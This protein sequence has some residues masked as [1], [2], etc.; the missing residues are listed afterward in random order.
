MRCIL[1]KAAPDLELQIEKLVIPPPPVATPISRMGLERRQA[2]IDAHHS[3]GMPS[4]DR[5]LSMQSMTGSYSASTSVSSVLAASMD[6]IIQGYPDPS[7]P[8]DGNQMQHQLTGLTREDKASKNPMLASLLDQDTNSPETQPPSMLSQLLNNGDNVSGQGK[9]KK[10]R[11]RKSMSDVRSPGSSGRSPK[12]KPNED[13]FGA[14]REFPGMDMDINSHGMN[15]YDMSGV[16]GQEHQHVNLQRPQQQQQAAYGNSGMHVESHVSRLA[17]SVDNIIKQESKNFPSV[18]HQPGMELPQPPPYVHPPMLFANEIKQEQLGNM[19]APGIKREGIYTQSS[20]TN[21]ISKGNSLADLLKTDSPTSESEAMLA[22][23]PP[24]VTASSSLPKK[25]L[26][27]LGQP[28]SDKSVGLGTK[29]HKSF[30][31]AIS[32]SSTKSHDY[33]RSNSV[34]ILDSSP[35]KIK[36]E[37]GKSFNMLATKNSIGREKTK[38]ASDSRLEIKPEDKQGNVVKDKVKEKKREEDQAP[39]LTLKLKNVSSSKDLTPGSETPPL[40]DPFDHAKAITPKDPPKL[41]FKEKF[42]GKDH[43]YDLGSDPEEA[44]PLPPLSHSRTTTLSSESGKPSSPAV[45]IRKIKSEDAIKLSKKIKSTNKY[46][47]DH[48]RKKRKDR[49]SDGKKDKIKRKK[50]YDID[51]E[52]STSSGDQP[53]KSAGSSPNVFSGKPMES[54]MSTTIRISNVAGKLQITPKPNSSSLTQAK[55]S[56]KTGGTTPSPQGSKPLK[57]TSSASKINRPP[58]SSKQFNRSRSDPHGTGTNR[59]DTKLTSKTPTIKLKPLVIPSSTAT[60]TVNASSS[61]VSHSSSG[62]STSSQSGSKSASTE[63][64]FSKSSSKPLFQ[65]QRKGSLSAV[66]ENLTNKQRGPPT[67][68]QKL[69]KIE[70]RSGKGDAVSTKNK[71]D[72]IYKAILEAAQGERK[73]KSSQR[74][75][76]SARLPSEPGFT[77]LEKSG[78]LDFSSSGT[79]PA[80]LPSTPIP[81]ISKTTGASPSGLP[82]IPKIG[83]ASKSS[84]GSSI[85]NKF[86]SSTSVLARSA[87]NMSSA[88]SSETTKSSA[89]SKEASYSSK[90]PSA[91]LGGSQAGKSKSGTSAVGGSGSSNQAS[92]DALRKES[93]NTFRKQD[94][95]VRYNDKPPRDNHSPSLTAY[96]SQNP[97]NS[98]KDLT[99]SEDGAK[100]SKLDDSGDR[101]QGRHFMDALG[102]ASS[103][104]NKGENSGK[105]EANSR[106]SYKPGMKRPSQAVSGGESSKSEQYHSSGNSTDRS[107]LNGLNV[108]SGSSS[109][110]TSPKEGTTRSEKTSVKEFST[111]PTSDNPVNSSGVDKNSGKSVSMNNKQVNNV[112]FNHRSGKQHY[113]QPPIGG[114][115]SSAPKPTTNQT[116]HVSAISSNSKL[117]NSHSESLTTSSNDPSTQSI[118]AQSKQDSVG[119]FDNK[120]NTD[121]ASPDPEN[122]VFKAPTP[123]TSRRDEGETETRSSRLDKVEPI[124]SPC[125]NPSS[126]EDSLVIDCPATPGSKSSKSPGGRSTDRSPVTVISRSPVCPNAGTQISGSEMRSK[127]PATGVIS[128][129]LTPPP[130]SPSTRK[131]IL[132]NKLPP[133]ASPSPPKSPMMQHNSPA[134][135]TRQSPVDIDDDLMDEAIIL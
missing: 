40:Q 52:F 104:G 105:G 29:N 111:K 15:S 49:E 122:G 54:K 94:Q 33:R 48:P 32:N 59:M 114:T 127:S 42:S 53:T 28:L 74:K 135:P 68:S 108:S 61:K 13:D 120:E 12:R 30:D 2:F 38:F 70:K 99:N 128:N 25:E 82:S 132:T 35:P 67:L 75:P 76:D 126:P 62:G 9:Q 86:S 66:I 55:S 103:H 102:S 23:P 97:H 45:K 37:G 39:R 31:S 16:L 80:S 22:P 50:I 110:R 21:K 118:N 44:E 90:G 129:K 109:S 17:S 34:E 113:N 98:S 64:T 81:K 26:G 123:K 3:G 112:D 124:R 65:K 57:T 46:D 24:P 72:A 133:P 117:T 51:S 5:Q 77:R 1:K 27:M 58:G 92:L 115:S 101:S 83:S 79:P 41:S 71:Q 100:K 116:S 119:S 84:V 60:V 56:P 131:P 18:P 4:V 134:L 91:T 78:K 20:A 87:S 130:P 69:E 121:I 10:P 89:G 107:R 7:P 73:I 11:K 125:S 85:P 6:A 96:N 106:E 88:Q 14:L 95:S 8:G 43:I 93:G 63:K 47:G 36:T 19:E